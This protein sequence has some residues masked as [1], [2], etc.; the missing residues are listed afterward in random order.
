[1]VQNLKS[2]LL[3]LY[4][5][6]SVVAHRF[7]YTLLGLDISTLVFLILCSFFYR[8]PFVDWLECAFGAYILLDFL[9]RLYIAPQSF[10]FL[11]RV[12][13]IIDMLVIISFFLP[14]DGQSFAFL[15][16]LSV[17]RL[18]RSA[19]LLEK[20]RRDISFF[21]KYEDMLISASNLLLFIFVM[22]EIV[23]QTQVGRNEDIHNFIDAMYFTVTTLTTTGFGD[24]VLEGTL[25]KLLTVIIMIFGVSLFLRLV[26]TIL[27]PHKVRFPCPKCGL[28]LHDRD[29]VHCKACGETLA[30]PDEGLD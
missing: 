12:F 22:T 3:E 27:R 30:I 14:V 25:G 7:R 8:H 6:D 21:R 5:G 16:A 17:I 20:L 11:T 18:L 10:A 15:R 26:Q 4:E 23:F 9:A 1:M 19:H 24:I 29:A 2:A 13:S 28:Y